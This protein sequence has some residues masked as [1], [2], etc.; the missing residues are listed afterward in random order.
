MK[1]LIGDILKSQAQTLVNTVN[2]VG[3]MGKGIA[4]EFK[5][6]FPEMYE[7]YAESCRRQE[8]KV[9]IPH[10]FK[11]L[12]PPQIVNF[13]TKTHWRALSNMSDIKKG[14]DYLL[15]H[16]KKWGIS[17][18]A[19]PPLGCGNGQLD[20]EYVGP[21]M[22]SRLKKMDIPVELYAPYGT[23]PQQLTE[24][25]LEQG[26]GRVLSPNGKQVVTKLNPAWI[27]LVEILY[28][29]EE[30]P[31]HPVIGRTIFQKIAYVATEQGLPTGLKYSRGSFGP[32]SQELK[33]ITAKLA[34][35]NLIREEQ[36]GRMFIVR[37]GSSYQ[38][39]RK[40]Y[41]V[42]FAQWEPIIEKT[43]DLFM[44]LNTQQ[45]EV[46]ATVLFTADQLK[47]RETEPSEKD[48]LEAVMQW[49]L[50][51]RPP[52]EEPEVAYTIRHLGILRWCDLI[53][54]RDLP[55]QEDELVVA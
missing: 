25:F 39:V 55:I 51:R 50:K 24:K 13:P 30:Q 41:E 31:Y 14:I 19:I 4:L 12:L 20:W 34:N 27:A 32:F 45:A 21:L 38:Q 54:S 49:K 2:C 44:R 17:S 40:R 15:E 10:L 22:Y 42:Q 16:Y 5:K 29:I 52:L 18:L 53:P 3:V 6:R 11:T 33:K 7:D 26:T 36:S 46:V 23:P 48:V 8:I 35:S 37:P 9:G 47:D 43:T 28:R 1:I